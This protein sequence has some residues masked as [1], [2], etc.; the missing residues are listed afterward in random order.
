MNVN[1][2][3]GQRLN[4]GGFLVARTLYLW[5]PV[6]NTADSC[7]ES[8]GLS[9]DGAASGQPVSSVSSEVVF[10]EAP[11][12]FSAAWAVSEDLSAALAASV[13]CAARASAR[14]A[15]RAPYRFAI[16]L[17]LHRPSRVS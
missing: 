6:R 4:R 17:I 14:G 11:V 8:Y 10:A 15:A 16:L 9:L 12:S 1:S 5:S 2:S 3:S 13:P 7:L